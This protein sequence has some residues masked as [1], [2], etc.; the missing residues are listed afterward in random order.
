M[1][2]QSFSLA[3]V[4]K[5]YVKYQ[6]Q[7]GVDPN[8]PCVRPWPTFLM[9]DLALTKS[10]QQCKT[11]RHCRTS[12]KSNIVSRAEKSVEMGKELPGKSYMLTGN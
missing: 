7:G 4:K 1:P 3:K 6:T 9:F 8:F 11:G 10:S 5:V 12:L 2:K